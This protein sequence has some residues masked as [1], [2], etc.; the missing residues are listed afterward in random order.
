MS[1]WWYVIGIAVVALVAAGVV[2]RS[3]RRRG[4]GAGRDAPQLGARARGDFA[5][6][7]E[8]D[9]LAHVSEEDRTWQAASLQRNRDAR[10]RDDEPTA[11]R[12]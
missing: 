4:N 7:R 5:Q 8:D 9:R 3:A 11:P 6:D 10:A 12:A 2:L 1:E